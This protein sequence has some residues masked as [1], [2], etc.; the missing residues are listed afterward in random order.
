MD[1]S[2]LKTASLYIIKMTLLW[3]ISVNI[4]VVNI[5]K[6]AAIFQS[7]RKLLMVLHACVSG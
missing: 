2:I 6:H 1:K 7:D 4:N 5:N 3:Y